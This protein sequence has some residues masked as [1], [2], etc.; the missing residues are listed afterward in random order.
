MKKHIFVASLLFVALLGLF[1]TAP[2]EVV[3][4]QVRAFFKECGRLL[5]NLKRTREGDATLLDR[6]TT[7][8]TSNLG[9]GSNHSNKDLPVLL[10]GGRFAHGRHL[11]FDPSTVPL[12]NLYVSILNQFG[13]SD[14]SFG[15]S[16]G[17]LQGLEFG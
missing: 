2:G 1:R 5:S 16:T 14:K 17:P 4:V 12:S 15:T 13:L 9:N 7:V 8:V 10:I 11:A 6:T 3:D